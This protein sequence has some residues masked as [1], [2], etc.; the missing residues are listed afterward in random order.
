MKNNKILKLSDLLRKKMK[1]PAGQW[2]VWCKRPKTLAEKEMVIIGAILTQNTN[3]KNVNYA[4][5]NLKKA[6]CLRLKSIFALGKENMPRL[7]ELIRPAGFFNSKSKYLFEISKFFVEHGGVSTVARGELGTLREKLLSLR[8]VGPETADSILLYA[9]GKP[10]FVIDEYTR[11]I[12]LKYGISEE[13][14]YHTLQKLFMENLPKE[15]GLF[16]DFHAFIVLAGQNKK[17]TDVF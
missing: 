1:K 6:D 11:R 4:L 12:C 9:L 17:N 10:I 2:Q 8:G 15:F 16:Q 7:A 14:D 5:D 13:K 3:W